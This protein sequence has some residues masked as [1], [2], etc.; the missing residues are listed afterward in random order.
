[1]TA[2]NL[3]LSEEL[4]RLGDKQLIENGTETVRIL[5]KAAGEGRKHWVVAFS[6]GKDSS[7]VASLI[8]ELLKRNTTLDVKVDVV[9]SDTLME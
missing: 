1:M 4:V 5:E 9:Y 8:V 2:L 3:P 6:G 7:L